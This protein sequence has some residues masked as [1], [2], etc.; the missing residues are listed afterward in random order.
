VL[1]YAARGNLT[2]SGATTYDYTSENRLATGKGAP[3][4][5]LQRSTLPL[6]LEMQAGQSSVISRRPGVGDA[7]VRAKPQR[8]LLDARP[9]LYACSL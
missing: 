3:L 8:T 9:C 2:S 7:P 5:A 6:R 4:V 1:E